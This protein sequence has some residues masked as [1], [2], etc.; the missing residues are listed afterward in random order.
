MD[1]TWL[2]DWP[3]LINFLT[4]A[5]VAC[6]LSYCVLIWN[7]WTR[8]LVLL[9]VMGMHLGIVTALGMPTF[10]LAMLIANV[11]FVSPTLIQMFFDAPQPREK[12]LTTSDLLSAANG[13]RVDGPAREISQR[14]PRGPSK[15]A[16]K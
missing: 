1:L 12:T 7:R 10:G 5:T 13:R 16:R 3:L 6:E 8:P 4:H 11:S 14:S 2:A 15:I 9:G